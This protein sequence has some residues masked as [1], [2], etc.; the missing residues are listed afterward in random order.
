MSER[1]QP[2]PRRRIVATLSV[3]ALATLALLLVAGFALLRSDAGRA[4]LEARIEAAASEPGGL[5]LSIGRL[6]GALPGEIRIED[7]VLG[8]PQGPWLTAD[9][10][11]LDWRPLALLRGRLPVETLAVGRLRIERAPTLPESEPAGPTTGVAIPELPVALT[12]ER[13]DIARLELGEALLGAEAALQVGGSA[14]ATAETSVMTTLSVTRL[15]GPAGQIE[16]TAALDPSGQS[17]TLD[18]Q[19][20][21]PAGGLVA[22][23]LAMPDLPEIALR[24]DGAG[25]LDAWRGSL[26]GKLGGLADW[27]GDIALAHAPGDSRLAVTG[28]LGLR[29]PEEDPLAAILGGETAYDL[30]IRLQEEE[31]LSLERLA[32]ESD[33]LALAAEG[34]LLLGDLDSDLTARL[35]LKRA[36]AMAAFAPDTAVQGLVVEAS[37]KG[38][39]L[40]PD[41]TA[42]AGAETLAVPGASASGLTLDLA[43]TSALPLTDPG[44]VLKL[45]GGGQV[46]ALEVEGAEA[47]QSLL[48]DG[49]RLDLDG[50]FELGAQRVEIATLSLGAPA[51]KAGARGELLLAESRAKLDLEVSLPDLAAFA[52]LAELPLAGRAR[53]RAALDATPDA[54]EIAL[55]FALEADDLTLGQPAAD[56]LLGSAPRATGRLQRDADGGLALVKLLVEGAA[57]QAEATA[58]VPAGFASLDS[59]YDLVLPDLAPLGDALG[60]DLAGAL[61]VTG[62]AEGPLA[63]PTID[64]TASVSGLQI[65]GQAVGSGS[66]TARVETPASALNGTLDAEFTTLAMPSAP[67]SLSTAFRRDGPSLALESLA[68]RGAGSDL[69]GELALDLD[70][71]LASGGLAGRIADLAPWLVLAGQG[72]EGSGRLS[73]S[74]SAADGR[75]AASAEANL[76]ALAITPRDGPAIGA[77]GLSLQAESDDLAALAGAATVTADGLRVDD[78]LVERLTLA[79]RGTRDA[80]DIS[81]SAASDTAPGFALESAGRLSLGD[82]AMALTVS[83]FEGTAFDQPFALQGPLDVRASDRGL[84]LRGLDL[85]VAT[86]R[87]TGDASL[88]GERIE[89]AL[90]VAELPLSVAREIAGLPGLDGTL[91]AALSVQGTA[92]APVGRASLTVADLRTAALAE[93][94]PLQVA[95]EADWRAARLALEGEIAGFAETPASLAL[96]LP[97]RLDPDGPTA[98]LDQDLP[99][100]GSLAWS[101]PIERVWPLVPVAD[102]TLSGAAELDATLAGT[103]AAP[104]VEGRLTVGDGRYENA[105]SGTLMS[106]LQ[107]AVRLSERRAVIE[108]FSAGDG[109]AGALSVEGSLDLLPERDFPFEVAATFTDFTAVRRDEVTGALGGGLAVE[110]SLAAT[111]VTG[112]LET[113]GVEIRIPNDLPPEVVDLEVRE[114]NRAAVGLSPLAGDEAAPASDVSLD[115]GV[116]LPGQVFVRGRGLDS[117]WRGDLRISGAAAAPEIVG[118]LSL[119][120]GQLALLGRDFALTRGKIDFPGGPALDPLLD[121]V[122]ENESDD[123][124][125]ALRLFGPA[126]RPAFE[127]T[128][129]PALPQDEVL[130]RVLFGKASTQLTPFEALQ[131]AS[132]AAELSGRSAGGGALDFAR[133][134]VGVDTLRFESDPSGAGAPAL[135]AGKAVTDEVYVGVKQ[136]ATPGSGSAGVE[137]EVFPNILLES[138]VGQ[139]GSSNLGVKFKWDY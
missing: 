55:P 121:I 14:G 9:R 73:L 50:L 86:G 92:P 125:V 126:S 78:L 41:V 18:L 3:A 107:V 68:L 37:A 133:D 49:L 130:A 28:A 52:A 115:L 97:L 13:L 60:N 34:T 109:G 88:D 112:A 19:A 117:E 21:E 122:A 106:D 81:L 5:S 123:L 48:A 79:G 131:L 12:V 11:A 31:R 94:P 26:S 43:A 129:Q 108:R 30:A 113:R 98:V 40:R 56:A 87:L 96:D 42:S 118:D 127:L 46:A 25:P 111:A 110:G 24:I 76:S 10:V 89:A 128:S 138:G 90:A 45:S 58:Q 53:L 101:G 135:A 139:G 38:P 51:F 23:L 104:R 27:R 99:L 105:L 85:T 95:L 22:G 6:A 70:S 2:R 74:L 77:A 62:K 32:L 84:A 66:A 33:T 1:E 7:L 82:D 91:A 136:G 124:T 64:A 29:L 8:D 137:I 15:D 47:L 63:D 83:R 134:L 54:A 120:R 69:G 102:Q 44:A 36:E 16:L 93:A 67:L 132:A 61:L 65:G 35:T 75:Q 114:V 17:L 119:V 103:A 80:L 72:G 71:G 100:A 57:L 4:W 116:T 39:L 59:T 20:A